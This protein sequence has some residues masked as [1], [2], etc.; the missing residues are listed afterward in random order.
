MQP[1]TT[2]PLIVYLRG[3]CSS[4]KS[5]F[6]KQLIETNPEWMGFDDDQIAYRHYVKAISERFSQEFASVAK[7]IAP[8]NLYHAFRRSEILFKEDAVPE[9]CEKAKEAIGRVQNEL[10][11]PKNLEWKKNINKLVRDEICQRIQ[12]A[13]D[14]KKP[15]VVDV[16]FYEPEEIQKLFPKARHFKVMLHCPLVISFERT[17]TR[18]QEAR[19]LPNL[20]DLRYV[21]QIANSFSALYQLSEEKSS[22]FV[23]KV[24]K[25]DIT[26]SFERMESMIAHVTHYEQPNFTL[27]EMT[28]KLLRTLR[29]TFIEPFNQSERR[30]LF[31]ELKSEQDLIIDTTMLKTQEAI[32]LFL[33]K[34]T[35]VVQVS[36]K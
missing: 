23:S 36:A 9:D 17:V 1:V 14:V 26:K 24:T 16:W 4:G 33:E 11:L 25:Q 2:Q 8:Q 21:E 35:Q 34:V 13:I 10:N 32:K 3:I 6:T 5:S 12:E 29:D 30:E 31:L 27:C 15:I 22:R 28:V 20:G 7:V 18:N 19:N